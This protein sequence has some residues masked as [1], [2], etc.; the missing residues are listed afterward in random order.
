MPTSAAENPYHLQR[1]AAGCLCCGSSNLQH[2]TQIV[3]GFLAARAWG[4]PPQLTQLVCCADCGLRFFERG[5]SESEVARYYRSYR[6]A[7]YVRDR[8]RWEIFYT[9]TQHAAQ[10]AWSHSAQRTEA[11]RAALTGADAPLR[12]ASALDHGGDHG[13]M[14]TAVEADRKAVFDPSARATLPGID[15]YA[16]SHLLPG[17]WDLILS[18]QV[19]EHVSVPAAYLREIGTLLADSGWLYLEVPV[20]QWRPAP[21]SDALRAAWLKLLLPSRPLLMV[22][23][24]LCT[25]SRIKLGRLPPLGF[26]AMREHL[27]YFTAAALRAIL[28]NGGFTVHTCGINRAGQLFAVARKFAT[29]NAG[30]DKTLST[31]TC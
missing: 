13:H 16:D 5:L 29:V 21:G 30:S 19:L 2:E 27:N 9:P 8:R 23:D 12:F 10:V 22:A 24:L 11:L 7:E 14:L 6:D 26:V 18:C 31:I 15:G 1:S 3:S 17:G 28:T 4:G 20:E 25:A